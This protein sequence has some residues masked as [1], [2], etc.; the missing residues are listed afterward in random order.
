MSFKDTINEK[1]L[2]LKGTSSVD[3]L[4]QKKIQD[5]VDGLLK[6]AKTPE[7]AIKLLNNICGQNQILNDSLLDL[8]MEST[9]EDLF[10]VVCLSLSAA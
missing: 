5:I 4:S 6:K 7:K 10:E 8:I 3:H 1:D 9:K 2:D